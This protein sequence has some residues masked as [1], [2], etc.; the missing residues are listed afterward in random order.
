MFIDGIGISGYRS[1]GSELQKIGPLGKINLLVGQNNSGKSNVLLFLK[2][3]YG[4][5]SES[6]RGGRQTSTF[7][8]DLDGHRGEPVSPVKVA[9]ALRKG[10]PNYEKVFEQLETPS[11]LPSLLERLL[12]SKTLSAGTDTAWFTCEAGSLGER[13]QIPT[14]TINL[15]VNEQVLNESEWCRLWEGFSGRR[16]GRIVDTWIPRTLE[17][18]AITAAEKPKVDIVPAIRRVGDPGSQAEDHSGSGLIERLA[19]LQNPDHSAQVLKEKFG[20]IN[21]FLRDV[22]GNKKAQIEVPYKRD[23]ILVH[24][25]GKTLPLSSLGTGI[26]EVVILAAAATLLE[27]QV[28][29]IEE[30]EL[31]LHPILQRKLVQYLADETTNQYVI[32]THS[33]HM[34]DVPGVAVFH[35]RLVVGSTVVTAAPTATDR[36]SICQDLG[37]RAS[38]I[39]QS[40]CV[41]WV[42]GPSDRVYI[43]HWLKALD[44]D[45]V[46]GIHY[47]IMFYGGRLL[48]HLSADDPAVDDAAVDEFISLRRLN[49]NI[50]VIMDSDRR[51]K[52]EVMNKAKRRVR[53]EFKNLPGFA[54][55]TQGREIEN[56]V[57]PRIL[58]D[59]VK[60]VCPKAIGLVATRQYSD[61]LRYKQKGGKVGD[62]HEK[63]KLAREV[64]NREPN[65]DVLDLRRK[66]KQLVE[67]IEQANR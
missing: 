56:Y 48:S 31:H 40:N 50:A 1:F 47:S 10:S 46:E 49:R 7:E 24:M 5:V 16:E 21:Q 44:C 35:V 41:I 4:F 23:T 8:S 64:A 11:R 13:L 34:I 33:A 63:V 43:N 3:H 52:G 20:R 25:D 26:H 28:V 9:F 57:A 59:A 62:V 53:D 67:F 15:L 66:I 6:I 51:V 61:C 36:S 14:E 42:E 37:Y 17:R 58:E 27:E 54:W 29:C 55:V 60:T 18:L 22:T 32:T 38:D 19:A 39:L 30:P 65:L 12:K 45:F 2:N